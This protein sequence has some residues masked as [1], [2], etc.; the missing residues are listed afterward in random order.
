[1]LTGT[2]QRSDAGFLFGFRLLCHLSGPP[3]P[4]CNPE[5]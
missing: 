4:R 1:V 5:H 3:H 2:A